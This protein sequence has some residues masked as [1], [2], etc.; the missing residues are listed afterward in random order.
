[1]KTFFTLALLTLLFSCNSMTKIT[2]LKNEKSILHHVSY[3]A[4]KR[5]SLIFKDEKTGNIILIS[6]PPPDVA[7]KLATE[8][9]AN[10][11]INDKASAELYL[12]TTKTIAELGKRT[13]SVN[14]LRD[15]LYKLSEMKMKDG[16]LDN[17]TLTLF[18]KILTI[19]ENISKTEL[20]NAEKETKDAETKL[21]NAKT[22]ENISS[23]QE[24]L[25][26]EILKKTLLEQIK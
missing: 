20:Q 9:K 24:N 4:S 25:N 3:D 10:A 26:N 18:D 23:S 11:N 13:A 22:L 19:T 15:A 16:N 14:I 2:N 12:N 8:L 21:S 6:E 17:N 1:M 7:T 5:G